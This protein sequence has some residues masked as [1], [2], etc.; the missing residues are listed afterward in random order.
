[1]K[2]WLVAGLI[3][4]LFVTPV[5]AT[6]NASYSSG[7][8]ISVYAF[9]YNLTENEDFPTTIGI[10]AS[11][12][13][14]TNGQTTGCKSNLTI[15]AYTATYSINISMTPKD[16]QSDGSHINW[17]GSLYVDSSFL[18]PSKFGHY[19][20]TAYCGNDKYILNGDIFY[21]NDTEAPDYANGG[22][23]SVVNNHTNVSFGFWD[24]SNVTYLNLTTNATN[25]TSWVNGLNTTNATLTMQFPVNTSQVVQ[26][27]VIANDTW[28]N[29]RIYTF[30]VTIDLDPPLVDIIDV[31]NYSGWTG[32]IVNVSFNVSDISNVTCELKLNSTKIGEGNYSSGNN[33]I[34]GNASSLQS[35]NYTLTLECEDSVGN[36][37]N[38][39]TNIGLDNTAPG[40]SFIEPDYS[41]TNESNV[42]VNVSI[43]ENE[44]GIASCNVSWNST[45]E[46]MTIAN[47]YATAN[48][49]LNDGIWDIT[50]KCKDNVD[51]EN[52]ITETIIIDTVPPSIITNVTGKT[53]S[54]IEITVNV[55]DENFN[56]TR[57]RLDNQEYE[58]N[59]S[60]FTYNFTGLENN[61]NYTIEITSCD[62]AGNCNSTNISSRTKAN[63][64]A[65]FTADKTSGYAPLTI[66]FN[67]SGSYDPDG[68]ITSYEWDFGDGTNATGITVNHTFSAGTYTVR[69]TVTDNEGLTAVHEMQITA[70]TKPS[71]GGGGGG[72]SGWVNPNPPTPKQIIK[73]INKM[74]ESKAG[75]FKE[76]EYDEKSNT[77]L[78]KFIVYGIGESAKYIITDN[79]PKQ[80]THRIIDIIPE[81]DVVDV[82]NIWIVWLSDGYKFTSTYNVSGYVNPDIF[83]EWS[84]K[85]EKKLVKKSERET[86]KKANE[87]EGANKGP[88]TSPVTGFISLEAPSLEATIATILIASALAAGLR[89]KEEFDKRKRFPL[90]YKGL[91]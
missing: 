49:S 57:V 37:A 70:R 67:A 90:K 77:T 9:P 68:S 72:S 19:N 2:Y 74:N 22:N 29:S 76:F 87:K 24:P 55:T 50:V 21:I 41:I 86:E 31:A 46:N 39:S 28:N 36:I 63:P 53:N 75:F 35:G 78:V 65:N 34:Q 4:A 88:V 38:D 6:G 48:K 89:V 40:L 14:T 44:S 26:V 83:K 58:T 32:K 64:I 15:E 16:T 3:V 18:D 33:T 79:I 17:N 27:N 12:T 91:Q 54:S 13:N 84:L 10:N 23:N 81:P 25:A 20:A 73:K 1:M 62:L 5:I 80:L 71:T 47:G 60:N 7:I 42:F 51:N 82:H 61:T 45:E 52:L 43:S 85:I 66:A 56:Y 11:F 30:F 8:S 59:D 69:L